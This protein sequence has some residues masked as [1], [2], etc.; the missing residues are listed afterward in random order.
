M[1]G[2]NFIHHSLN[3]IEEIVTWKKFLSNYSLESIH[4]QFE[5]SE[6]LT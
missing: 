3:S 5:Y 2:K 4:Q 6:L 1:T